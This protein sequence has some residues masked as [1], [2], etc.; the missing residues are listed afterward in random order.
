MTGGAAGDGTGTGWPEVTGGRV[1][2]EAG[3]LGAGSVTF[4]LTTF[5]F[6]LT[7][8]QTVL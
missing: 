7:G 6:F 3:G 8:L 1:M 2:T 4:F 5:F